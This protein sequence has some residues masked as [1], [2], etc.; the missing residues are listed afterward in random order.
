MQ[1][2][3][4][5][6]IIILVVLAFTSGCKAENGLQTSTNKPDTIISARLIVSYDFG[7]NI[8]LDKWIEIP[9][10]AN[11]I[12]A[13]KQHTDTATAYGGGFITSVDD[14]KS[15][16]ISSP[17]T[18]QDWFLYINGMLTNTGGMAYK[19]HPGDTVH[20]Y[21]RDWSFRQSVSALVS[22]FAEPFVSGYAG[23]VAPTIIVHENGWSRQALSLAKKLE[24][25]GVDKINTK[26]F[27]ALTVE[28]METSNI[29]ALGSYDFGLVTLV[30]DI[31][32]RLGLFARFNEG[33]L[34]VYDV[35]GK[36]V[37]DYG[38]E[39]GVILAMQNPFNP[40][41]TGA[42]ENVLWLISG[43]DKDGTLSALDILLVKPEQLS[44]SAGVIV[45][46]TSILPLP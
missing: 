39:T 17:V 27:D 29:I 10:G 40:R 44:Y 36:L 1:A 9:E 31:W 2:K 11:A 16:Y 7:H 13:L 23:R 8:I 25:T 41:G 35:K 22:D 38:S 42:C 21:Y 5:L 18:R 20:W 19:I 15:G 3:R 26:T 30:N 43:T 46:P 34:I 6:F 4:F 12:D 45:T 24:D 28:E 37:N 32:D 14:V 33:K